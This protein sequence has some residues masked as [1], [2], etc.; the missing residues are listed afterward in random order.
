MTVTVKQKTEPVSKTA[1][2]ISTKKNTEVEGLVDQLGAVSKKI[3]AANKRL[4]PLTQE[5]GEIEKELIGYV[6]DHTPPTQGS[7]LLGAQYQA[8]FSA[9][10]AKT[11]IT[12]THIAFNMLDQVQDGLPWELIS[13]SITALRKYL[14]PAQLE[15]ITSVDHVIKRRCKLSAK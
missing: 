9:N 12:D 1:A 3:V 2:K 4:A 8:E 10:G 15:E 5:Y 6:D 11:Q 14:T 13:F 7:V